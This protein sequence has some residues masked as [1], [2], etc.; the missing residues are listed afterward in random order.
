MLQ[1][2]IATNHK[3]CLETYRQSVDNHQVC[4]M[5]RNQVGFSKTV[6]CQMLEN[7]C[8]V[9]AKV[10]LRTKACFKTKVD[11]FSKVRAKD[12]A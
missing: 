9:R 7:R 10:F 4:L 5:L 2:Q 11:F 3:V 8:L 12:K 1:N 6:N